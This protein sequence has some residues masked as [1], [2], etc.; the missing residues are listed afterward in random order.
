MNI[1]ER[2]KIVSSFNSKWKYRKDKEQYGMLDAWKI[3]Y[4]E[5][6]EQA[7]KDALAM[8]KAMED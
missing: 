3:I 7:K 2:N 8:I 1:K 6:A 5:N 4:S